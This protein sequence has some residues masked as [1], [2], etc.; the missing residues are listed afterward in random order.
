[1]LN[2]RTTRDIITHPEVLRVLQTCDRQA[3]DVY[4]T[5]DEN[6]WRH[7]AGRRWRLWMARAGARKKW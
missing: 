7:V 4:F 6:A 5:S 1:M 2:N 3:Q